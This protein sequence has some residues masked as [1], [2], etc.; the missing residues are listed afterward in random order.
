MGKRSGPS[1][2]SALQCPGCGAPL[3]WNGNVPVVECRY[4]KTHVATGTGTKTDSAAHAVSARTTKHQTLLVL[5]PL[6]LL[7]MVLSVAGAV[8]SRYREAE[9]GPRIDLAEVRSFPLTSTQEQ[10]LSRLK[11][12]Q[13]SAGYVAVDV[14]GFHFDTVQFAWKEEHPDHVSGINMFVPGTQDNPRAA[15]VL[16]ALRKQFGAKLRELPDQYVFTASRARVHLSKNLGGLYVS[17][18]PSDDAHWKPRLRLLWKVVLANAEGKVVKVDDVQS[19]GLLGLGFPLQEVAEVDIRITLDQMTALERQLPGGLRSPKGSV[20]YQIPVRHGVFD[21][22][23]FHFDNEPGGRLIRLDFQTADLDMP[24]QDG[25]AACLGDR[26]GKMTVHVEDHALGKRRHDWE[27][28]GLG[29]VA[30]SGTG[31]TIFVP[32][33]KGKPSQ[34]A[35]KKT[36]STVASCAARP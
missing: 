30:L 8:T 5:V 27:V 36:L 13:P 32:P 6:I 17:V 20:D 35:W 25:L 23:T 2:G 24:N 26:V 28:P 7:I 22:A 9:T 29:G 31:L 10:A 14:S 33:T 18:D 3:R 12:R 1:P 21:N 34:Q 19:K 16:D 15:T 11:G 4:C